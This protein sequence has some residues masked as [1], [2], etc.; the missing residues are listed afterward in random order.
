MKQGFT[1]ELVDIPLPD[2][3][4]WMIFK[5]LRWQWN[6][7]TLEEV[8]KGFITDYASV[9]DLSFLAAMAMLVAFAASHWWPATSVGLFWFA[10]GICVF[11]KRIDDDPLTDKGAAFHDKDYFERKKPRYVADWHLVI[12]MRAVGV[13]WWKCVLYWFNLR[14]FGWVAWY[15]G[16][17]AKRARI[18]DQFKLP[19]P[20]I[21]GM[22]S[23]QNHD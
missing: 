8:P 4:H 6:D 10:W 9:P 17:H 15:W 3:K 7:G 2:G 22:Q 18:A 14:L 11:A 20:H 19:H 23:N 16:D 13:G 21:S 12:R 1:T 5:P